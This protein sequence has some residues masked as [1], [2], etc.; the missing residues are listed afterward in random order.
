[1]INKNN[2]EN[3]YGCS[4]LSLASTL[5]IWFPIIETDFSDSK[6]AVFYFQQSQELQDTINNYWRN[7][8]LVEPKTLFQSIKLLKSRIYQS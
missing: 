2:Y 5:Y 1:M 6:K 3:L 4:D 7:E 8:L